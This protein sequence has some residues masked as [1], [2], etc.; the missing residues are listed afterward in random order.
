MESSF[1]SQTLPA[2]A[3]VLALP[4]VWVEGE[5]LSQFARVASLPGCIAARAMPDLH[6]G[7]GIPI[8]A[9]FAFEDRILPALVGSDAGCGVRI[10]VTELERAGGAKLERRLERAFGDDPL[11]VEGARS[12]TLFEAVWRKG[13]RGLADLPGIPEPLARLAAS[14]PDD[15]LGASG[16]PR[17]YVQ[18]F[19]D[20]LGTIGGGNHFAEIAR[21]AEIQDHASA[22]NMGLSPGRIVVLCHSGSR[23]L[24]GALS[25]RWAKK[26]LGPEEM[27]L[28]LGELR[29]ACRFARANRLVIAYRLLSAL[30]CTREG[31]W[32]SSFDITHNDVSREPVGE[33]S[34]W[35]HRKG[36]A[37]ARGRELTV[38]LGSRGA[39]S[40]IL[41][42]KGAEEHLSSVAHGAG[43]RMGRSEA[44]EK[45][46]ARY[47]R[48]ELLRTRLGGQVLCDDPALL[49]EEHPDAYKPIGKVMNSLVRFGLAE[50][51]ASLV[52][53][54]TIK[55]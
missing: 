2:H 37:P 20:A 55:R 30:G 13:E 6:A 48:S 52:P 51:V 38:V 44:R 11:E 47:K 23:G 54:F 31:A 17:P 14:I 50:P 40:W 15:G 3:R 4:D 18:G 42:A 22:E 25:T 16:D 12:R 34:A 1:S 36:A 21:V 53:M 19:E 39:P 24:G 5:A 45:L 46:K 28:Y 26:T 8:G 10:V 7:R 49:Y 27:L 43:R 33:Q 35:V 41:R 32:V 9:V 29:G